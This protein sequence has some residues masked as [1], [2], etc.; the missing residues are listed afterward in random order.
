MGTRADF[1]MGFGKTAE[2]LGSYGYDGYGPSNAHFD[3]LL[4]KQVDD[5]E[6]LPLVNAK[7]EAEWRAAV[8]TVTKIKP[9]AGWPWPWDDGRLTDYSYFWTPEEGM[10]CY[11]F[12]NREYLTA[13]GKVESK[14]P[15]EA[16]Y[17]SNVYGAGKEDIF[18]NMKDVQN[19]DLGPNSGI[20]ILS[21]PS[22]D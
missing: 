12:G 3:K 19:V 21:V 5:K 8:A 16:D 22:K 14:E 20:L 15:T 18:R 7:T 11:N 10:I 2:W 17:D 6:Q 4:G 1:Y 9:D 13:E